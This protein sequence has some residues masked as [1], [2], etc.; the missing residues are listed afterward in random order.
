MYLLEI[1]ARFEEHHHGVKIP[2]GPFGIHGE[3]ITLGEAGESV[4]GVVSFLKMAGDVL[5]HD[6]A[7][8]LVRA[9]E[10]WEDQ[11]KKKDKAKDASKV[12]S[13]KMNV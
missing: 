5:D 7:L 8:R 10:E 11:E 1:S 2:G 13:T 12:C 3:N 6:P 9:N 4:E